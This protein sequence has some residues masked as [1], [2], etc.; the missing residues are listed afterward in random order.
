MAFDYHMFKHMFG[1][2]LYD[3][4]LSL[5]VYIAKQYILHVILKLE[6]LQTAYSY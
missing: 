4:M 2:H 6:V 1:R 3:S 5:A